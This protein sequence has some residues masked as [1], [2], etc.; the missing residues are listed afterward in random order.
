MNKYLLVK[1]SEFWRYGEVD[2]EGHYPHV[3]LDDFNIDPKFNFFMIEI[4]CKEGRKGEVKY[5][6]VASDVF[7]GEKFEFATVKNEDTGEQEFRLSSDYLGLYTIGNLNLKEHECIPSKVSGLM[8]Y[9]REH[10]EVLGIYAH[11]SL[12]AIDVSRHYRECYLETINGPSNTA[13]KSLRRESK[14]L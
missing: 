14:Y 12:A 3:Q 11:D 10:T 1:P 5:S 7:S 8:N 4:P 9:M 2:V 13:K 6:N